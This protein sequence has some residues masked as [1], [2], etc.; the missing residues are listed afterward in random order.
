MS[1]HLYDTATRSLREFVP[2]RPG[3]ASIYVCG[4]TV[5]GVPHIG[6]V[7]SALNYDVLRRWLLATGHDVLLVRNVTDIDDKILARAAEAGRPWWEWAYTHERAFEDAYT[8]LGCLPPSVLPRAT[9][10]VPQM[11]ELMA[12]LIDRGHAY[13]A[14]GD[15]YFAVAT[16]DDYG[17]LS[18]QR[19]DDVSQ[20]ES[21]ASGKRDPRDFTL[22]KGAKP[23]EPS[24][25]TP[26]GPGRP[27]WHLE[28][29]AMATT[30]LGPEF[31]IHGGGLDLVFPHHENERAQ[32]WAAGNGF[33]RYWLHNGWVTL[34]GEKMSKSL[35]NT[36]SI[37]AILRR[38]R[39]VELRYYLVG[40]HYRSAI[41]YSD[42]ALDEAVAAYQRIE[43]FVHRVGERCGTPEPGRWSAEFVGS[44]DDDLGTPAALAVIH[45]TV[46][47]GNAALD[48]GDH[49]AAVRA[50]GA[51]RAM[52][53]V[54]G[55]DPLADQW[56]SASASDATSAALAVLVDWL[57]AQR[58]EA[59]N[60]RDYATADAVRNQLLAA[61]I[62]VEDTPDGPVWTVKGS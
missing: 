45:T 34:S 61:G 9:G 54:L 37:P 57:L 7:R 19:P 12:R 51:V 38:V 60:R 48:A 23:G 3:M 58:A 20:G 43:S 5:Q 55:L 44:M 59:R 17:S 31:D 24:W 39:A 21:A 15:V 40:A 32:S 25:P 10:H 6:H 35:G 11:V 14:D 29:S 26:W 22:W 42:G 8:A 28:C 1:L 33:A 46:H 56:R 62:A 41:E 53:G 18:G 50:A 2:L 16:M 49:P 52:T 36:L 27:G 47:E 30:Y 4:A 13:A